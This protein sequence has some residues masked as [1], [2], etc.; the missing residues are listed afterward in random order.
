MRRIGAK[1]SDIDA[2]MSELAANPQGGDRLQRLK[3][4]RKIRF[5][6]P[7]RN[8]GKGEAGALF[9]FS[10]RSRTPRF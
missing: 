10:S 6:L 7:S 5:G 8:L 1:E 3:G 9:I 2:L 4:V